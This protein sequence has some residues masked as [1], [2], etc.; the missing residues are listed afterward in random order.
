MGFCDTLPDRVL[1]VELAVVNRQVITE[2]VIQSLLME[3]A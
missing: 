1:T 2:A 3:Q